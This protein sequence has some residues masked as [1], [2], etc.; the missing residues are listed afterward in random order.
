MR[1][2]RCPSH[3][4]RTA[5]FYGLAALILIAMFALWS[6]THPTT[7]S[8]WFSA[9]LLLGGMLAFVVLRDVVLPRA[10]TWI[11]GSLGERRV[12]GNL[13]DLS[14]DYV[15]IT[16]FIVPET[17]RG[18]IDLILIG[19]MGIVTIEVKCYTGSIVYEGGRWWRR[20]KNGWKTKITK[21]LS[22]QARGHSSSLRNY[23]QAQKS[24]NRD[25]VETPVPLTAALVFVGTT[26]LEIA[27][28]DIAVIKDSE[29]CDYL[30]SL[31]ACLNEAGR[32]ALE[33]LLVRTFTS[34]L[35]S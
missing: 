29:L 5:Q 14:D 17:T 11:A 16:N 3:T 33:K 23:L 19:P 35:T 24:T 7:S 21:N 8:V 6:L 4:L 12:L 1:V 30:V 20:Q 28:L 27:P 34:N 26:S 10:E 15:A 25:L 31:P 2:I 22:S 18:D 13:C 9:S 32:M